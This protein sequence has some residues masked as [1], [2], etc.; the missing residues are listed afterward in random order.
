MARPVRDG[1]AIAHAARK[2][3]PRPIRRPIFMGSTPREAR[4]VCDWRRCALRLMLNRDTQYAAN[5]SRESTNG[6]AFR[7]IRKSPRGRYPGAGTLTA[8]FAD[9]RPRNR[10]RTKRG[11]QLAAR[12]YYRAR[13]RTDAHRTGAGGEA[14]PLL[15]ERHQTIARNRPALGG[16][17]A[18]RSP[19]AQR[20]VGTFIRGGRVSAL[21]AAVPPGNRVPRSNLRLRQV[22][23]RWSDLEYAAG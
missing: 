8:W 1:E 21:L 11:P 12:D 10:C 9:L 18:R 5:R 19:G 6:F 14:R 15:W 17:T 23:V 4:V 3:K 2:A 22:L 20:L 16:A 13:W 7:A